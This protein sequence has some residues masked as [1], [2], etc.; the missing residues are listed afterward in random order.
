MNM[1]QEIFD[2]LGIHAAQV[3]LESYMTLAAATTVAILG[4]WFTVRL[5]RF[6]YWIIILCVAGMMIAGATYVAIQFVSHSVPL[7]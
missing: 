6:L 5:A 4:L 2:S 7:H 1:L 3:P